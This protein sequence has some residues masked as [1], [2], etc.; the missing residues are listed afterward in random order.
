MKQWIMRVYPL[1]QWRTISPDH[2]GSPCEAMESG[3]YTSRRKLEY[4]ENKRIY[5]G[6]KLESKGQVDKY[7][8]RKL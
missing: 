7:L 8:K 2:R 6:G 5:K 3:F 4:R 1:I